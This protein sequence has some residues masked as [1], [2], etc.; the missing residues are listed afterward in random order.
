MTATFD[1]RCGELLRRIGR[2]HGQVVVDQV[3][4]H[5]QHEHLEFRHPRGGIAEY[6]RVPLY[7]HFRD[8]FTAI[9]RG[10]L[11]DGGRR[12]MARSME[13][14]SG[15][16]EVLAPVEFADLRR[17]GHPSASMDGR[18]FYDRQPEVHRLTEAELR[19]KARLRKLPP[20]IL[21]W[22]WWHVMGHREPPPHGSRWAG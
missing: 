21:G 5:Y 11:D 15:Q 10:V 6:L 13:H 16:V 2:L 17:S 12:D 3:Y 22:I 18:T 19:A 14:L 4:A 9:G 8:Y 20:E 7:L 1:E